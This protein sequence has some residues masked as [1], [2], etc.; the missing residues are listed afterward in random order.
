MKPIN[1]RKEA[2]QNG[3]GLPM[4]LKEWTQVFHQRNR[5]SY[6]GM[7]VVRTRRYTVVRSFMRM[8]RGEMPESACI[9]LTGLDL[10]YTIVTLRFLFLSLRTQYTK[11][12]T[13]SLFYEQ[14]HRC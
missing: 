1:S 7:Q 11:L 2:K 13:L 10:G 8:R 5:A 9:A 3:S 4:H 14:Q 6:A 12:E